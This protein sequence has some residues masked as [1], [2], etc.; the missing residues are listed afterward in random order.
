MEA[1]RA[2]REQNL[3]RV[4]AARRKRPA[5]LRCVECGAEFEGRKGELIC[6]RRC[7]DRRYARLHPDELREKQRRKY[8]RR[9]AA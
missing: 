6:S 5:K 1:T 4:N 3:E 2:W 8:A 9:K 7:K